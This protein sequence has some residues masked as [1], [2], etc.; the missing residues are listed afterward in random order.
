MTDKPEVEIHDW[1]IVG[2]I[3]CGDAVDHPELGTG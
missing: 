3:L 2:S 1:Y